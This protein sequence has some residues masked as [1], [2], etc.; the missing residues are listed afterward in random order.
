MTTTKEVNLGEFTDADFRDAVHI[1]VIPVIYNE[2]G[3]FPACHVGIKSIDG[4]NIFVSKSI[5]PYVGVLDP[6]LKEPI[7]KND[8][9]WLLLYPK[10]IK[11]LR[12]NWFHPA[13][14]IE[15][16][17]KVAKAFSWM[18]SYAIEIGLNVTELLD[19]AKIYLET[20]ELLFKGDLLQD[21][22]SDEFWDKYE[23]LTGKTI[24]KSKKQN[25]F[26]CAC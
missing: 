14:D 11:G 2:D 12:H 8:K 5:S 16:D 24:E 19:G 7:G 3:G 10:T 21:S 23:I 22:V 4:K 25:F 13:F 15:N 9:C 18:N 20:G 6:F 26:S 17:E 1:A